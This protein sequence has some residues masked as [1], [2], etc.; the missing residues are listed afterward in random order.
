[1]LYKS[2]LIEQNFSTLKNNI[3]LFYGENIGLKKELKDLIKF[4]NKNKEIIKFLQDQ[5]LKNEN[6]LFNEINNISLFERE[7]IIIIDNADD[8]ILET[9]KEIEDKTY[10]IKIYIF[11]EILEKKSKIRNYFEKSKKYGIVPCYQDNE[12]GLKKIINNKLKGYEGLT[13]YN[14]NLIFE[15]CDFDR[16][17]LL[18]EIEKIKIFFDKKKIESI[19]L[20]ML[21]NVKSSDN[22][23]YLKDEALVGNIKKTNK[24]LSQTIIEAEK[25]MY[26]LNSINQR[27]DKLME[28]NQSGEKNL[29]GIID[30]L[31]PPIFWKDKPKVIEQ[32]K[33]W[34]LEKTKKMK[35]KTYNFEVF[36]KSNSIINKDLLVR[37]LIIDMCL[38]ANA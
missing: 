30:N 8:K 6:I 10:E 2:Y 27:L 12:I 1:M 9:L 25:I 7:K 33:K 28:I 17:K 31:K 3:T 20:Q 11:S 23:D 21:L 38:L 29:V 24:L 16:S 35:E 19:D 4:N 13:P 37:K 22:F 34:S 18:N 32:A 14:V 15:N 5:I 26:Y 36:I